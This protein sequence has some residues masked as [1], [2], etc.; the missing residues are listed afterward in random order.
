MDDKWM[1]C[2]KTNMTYLDCPIAWIANKTE[3]FSIAVA[4]HNP[5]SLNKNHFDILVPEG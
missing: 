2:E 3:N 5:S 4:A 1:Q